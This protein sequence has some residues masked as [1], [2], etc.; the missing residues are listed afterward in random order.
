MLVGSFN[1]KKERGKE[2]KKREKEGRK[3]RRGDYFP[4]SLKPLSSQQCLSVSVYVTVY[5]KRM[6]NESKGC[7]SKWNI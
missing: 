5:I 6:M 2:G 3:R 1:E 4:S 7:K